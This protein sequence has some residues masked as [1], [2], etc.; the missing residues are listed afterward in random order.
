[1]RPHPHAPDRTASRKPAM[2][3]TFSV[4]LAAA[5]LALGCSDWLVVPPLNSPSPGGDPITTAQVLAS[6]ILCQKR[7]TFSDYISDV[8]IS[9]RERFNYFPTGGR[10]QAPS[11]AQNPLAAAG[12]THGGPD[13]RYA[14]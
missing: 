7:T 3:R 11:V 2:A 1:M 12:F 4:A 5:L 10:T 14:P 8:G 6:G 13:T 9:G